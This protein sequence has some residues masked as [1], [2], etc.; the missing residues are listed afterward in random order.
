MS[1][2]Q[3]LVF[4]MMSGEEVITKVNNTTEMDGVILKYSVNR[5]HVLKFQQ[6]A[7]GEVG[8]ALVPWALSNPS[9]AKLD[10]PASSIMLVF[11]PDTNATKQYLEQTSGISLSLN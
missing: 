10:I 11:E 9:I 3:V 6:I 4:K 5:P 1:V 7:P 2:S 8:L